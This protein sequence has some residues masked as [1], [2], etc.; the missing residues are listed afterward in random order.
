MLQGRHLADKVNGRTERRMGGQT[1]ANSIAPLPHFV[2][3]GTKKLTCKARFPLVAKSPYDNRIQGMRSKVLVHSLS[4]IRT[5][6][7]DPPHP[8]FYRVQNFTNYVIPY[9]IFTT[10]GWGRSDT[11][12]FKTNLSCFIKKMLSCTLIFPK[13]P[14]DPLPPPILYGMFD[15]IP[16]TLIMLSHNDRRVLALITHLTWKISLRQSCF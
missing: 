6:Q 1:V 11:F 2:R 10:R 3:R 13:V 9:V 5:R 8:S 12:V 16:S 14:P 7:L 4:G 15:L